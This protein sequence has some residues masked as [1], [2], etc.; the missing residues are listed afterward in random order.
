MISW[1]IR[2]AVLQ[3]GLLHSLISFIQVKLDTPCYTDVA[4]LQ[5]ITIPVPNDEVQYS[6]VKA[7]H[8]EEVSYCFATYVKGNF[9]LFRYCTCI[10]YLL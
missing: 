1:H 4:C 2:R 5:V 9:K 3:H 10:L 7:P 8:T 6:E